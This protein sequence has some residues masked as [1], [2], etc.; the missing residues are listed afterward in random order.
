MKLVY[1]LK[2]YADNLLSKVIIIKLRLQG[3]TIGAN[4]FIGSNIATYWPHKLQIGSNCLLE[5]GVFFKYDGIYSVGKAI[6]IGER[7][8]IGRFTEFNIKLNINIGN[9][10]LIASNTKFV[11]HDHGMNR[12]DIM[13]VQDCDSQAISIGNDVWIGANVVLLKGV[14]IGDGAV[15]AAGSVVTKSIPEFEVWGGVP[16]RK[17]SQR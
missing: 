17:I 14:T 10:C 15:V 3:A 2:A 5:E 12:A 9:D 7:C 16:A 1:R 6:T 8:F 13:S 4:T 11:D